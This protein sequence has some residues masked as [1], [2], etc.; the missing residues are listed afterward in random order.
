M[1]GERQVYLS[2]ILSCMYVYRLCCHIC[3]YGH[4]CEY[5]HVYAYAYVHICA[6]IHIYV[7]MCIYI[8]K[9]CHICI[10]Y[11]LSYMYIAYT[12]KYDRYAVQSR[13]L[14]TS[15]PHGCCMHLNPVN[16]Q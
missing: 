12:V 7:H 11:I 5:I 16:A 13:I 10:P 9:Y 1:C 14:K 15:D 2:Y 6:Y 8:R 4:I 3:I